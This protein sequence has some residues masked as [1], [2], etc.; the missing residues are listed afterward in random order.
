MELVIIQHTQCGMERFAVPE[1]A[2]KVTER[3]GTPDVVAT[4]GIAD[5]DQTVAADIERLR[6]HPT[7]PRELEVSGHVYDVATGRLREVVDARRWDDPARMTVLRHRFARTIA[8]HGQIA[9]RRVPPQS[10]ESRSRDR[11]QASGGQSL[12]RARYVQ[13]KGIC[14]VVQPEEASHRRGKER[15]DAVDG[16]QPLQATRPTTPR[17]SAHPATRPI[18]MSAPGHLGRGP[19]RETTVTDR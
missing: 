14:R 18:E 6:S 17:Q 2:A 3:F 9:C 16:N 12:G 11:P 19:G 13:P 1:V 4:Y 15:Y 7:V 8:F 10:G 5:V